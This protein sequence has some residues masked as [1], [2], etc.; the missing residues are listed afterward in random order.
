MVSSVSYNE[1]S[2]IDSGNINAKKI[3]E[4]YG[5]R[6]MF[7]GGLAGTLGFIGVNTSNIIPTL[8]KYSEGAAAMLVMTTF[9]LPIVGM[10]T[11]VVLG[12]YLG[13]RRAKRYKNSNV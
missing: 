3:I 7:F 9:L 2:S 13:Y 11:G 5:I 6:G 4:S 10:F 12:D 1:N 8:N